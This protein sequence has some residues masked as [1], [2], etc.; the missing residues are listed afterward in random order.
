MGRIIEYRIPLPLS[1]DEY[2]IGQ[3][4]GVAEASKN[5]TGGGDGVEVVENRPFTPEECEQYKSNGQ[6]TYKIM[7]LEN[8][9]P[10]IIV[11]IAP[12]GSL[13]MH[14]K[15]WNAYPYCKTIYSNEYMEDSFHINIFTWHKAG[16]GEE[17][18]HGLDEATL[19]EREIVNIDIVDPVDSHDYKEDEDPSKFKSEKTGR[20]PL[21]KGWIDDQ[22]IQPKMTCYKFYDI[23][24]KWWGLQT[25]VEKIIARSVERLLRN[26]HRQVFCW[27]DQW[28]GMTMEDIRCLEDEA[29]C[30]LDKMRKYGEAKGSKVKDDKEKGACKK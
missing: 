2:K 11:A 25:K 21:T 30:E 23:K 22:S 20:G 19:K 24:F 10:R 26:F 14:E 12:K 1:V 29:K 15:A 27:I 5:E 28:F 6:Y 17:N 13:Q 16:V 9:L 18:V 3:L 4:Y 8:K 7:H